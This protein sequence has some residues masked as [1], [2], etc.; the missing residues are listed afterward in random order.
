MAIYGAPVSYQDDA[1]RAIRTALDMQAAFKLLREHWTDP[2][3]RSLD[4]GIG[5]NT[6]EAVV[7]NIGTESLMDYTVVGDAVNIAQRLE[8][9]AERGQILI[10]DTVYAQVQRRAQVIPYGTKVLRGRQEATTIY[11]LTDML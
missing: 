8:E 9:L 6:G 4:L 3:E 7:G 1:L 11:T 10:S 5:I 2:E